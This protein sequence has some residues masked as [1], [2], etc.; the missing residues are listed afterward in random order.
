MSKNKHILVVEDEQHL[1]IGIKFNLQREGYRVTTVG[2][3]PSA[4]KVFDENPDGIDLLILDLMLPGMSGY[5]V[6]ESLREAGQ[7]IPVLILSARTLTEDRTR[8]FDVGADQYLSKPFDLEE[9]LSRVRNLLSLYDRRAHKE[10]HSPAGIDVF[11][12][13]G[14]KVDFQTYEVTVD[15]QQVRMTQLEMKLLHY[16]V[17]HQGRVISR[18]ELLEN[19]WGM[20]GNITTRAVDQFIRRLR[21][22]FEPDPTEPRHFL[23]VRDAGYRFVPDAPDATGTEEDKSA[24]Y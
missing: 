11:E 20:P 22:T 18:E 19:V 8:G 2:D 17:E 4:L 1:V 13:S 23:T 15:G 14:A 21:K 12:F 5:A 24:S 7:D 6:C 16:F 9:L 3:G 10:I